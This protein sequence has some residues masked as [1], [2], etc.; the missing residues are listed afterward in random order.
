MLWISLAVTAFIV[1]GINRS[2]H[3]DIGPLVQLFLGIFVGYFLLS[4]RLRRFI[5]RVKDTPALPPAP[6]KPRSPAAPKAN[7]GA[8]HFRSDAELQDWLK[9]NQRG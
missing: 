4:R 2:V 5:L 9:T 6:T 1:I 8:L 3:G 7:G